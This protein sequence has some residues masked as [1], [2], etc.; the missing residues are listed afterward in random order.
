MLGR[1]RLGAGRSIP[2]PAA[3]LIATA[4]AVIIALTVVLLT[5]DGGGAADAGVRNADA[6][7]AGLDRWTVVQV[8]TNAPFLPTLANAELA[9][10]ANRLSFTITGQNGR[11]RGDLTVRVGLFDLSSDPDL[12][13]AEQF[14][15]FIAYGAES[16]IPTNHAHADGASL[17]DDA[18]YV[19]AGVYVVPAFFPTAGTWGLDFLITSEGGPEP[20]QTVLFRVEVRERGAAPRVGELAPSVASRTLVDE[21]DI[22]ALTSDLTPEPGLYQVSIEEALQRDRPFVVIFA[23]PAFCHSRT[24]G[25]SV[26]VVKEV[27]RSYAAQIDAIHVEVFENPADPDALREAPAF[28]AWNLPSEPWVFVVDGDG[29]ITARFEGTITEAELRG[30]VRRLVGE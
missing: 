2:W 25:P 10:G 19:G 8:D 16:P 23:T 15:Q 14:A 24:C 13:V 9:I 27:W 18:R 29:R 26:E 7:G 5:Q 30:E 22:R 6:P 11:I 21:P 4:V 1:A 17:S 3:V 12:P 20:P 28:L